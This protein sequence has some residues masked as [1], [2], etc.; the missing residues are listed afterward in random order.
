MT[1]AREQDYS[2]DRE[3]FDKGAFVTV[4]SDDGEYTDMQL[5]ADEMRAVWT[6]LATL[7]EKGLA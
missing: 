4:L 2:D 5:T 1:T 3:R 6:A 7:P